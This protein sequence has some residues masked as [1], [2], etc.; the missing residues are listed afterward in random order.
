MVGEGREGFI[1]SQVKRQEPSVRQSVRRIGGKLRR[2]GGEVLFPGGVPSGSK[3]SSAR[4]KI[5]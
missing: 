4:R 2:L 5:G 1:C 3:S